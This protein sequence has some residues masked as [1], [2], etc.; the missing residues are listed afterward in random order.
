MSHRRTN[1]T[2][3]CAVHELAVMRAHMY[4]TRTAQQF[5][6]IICTIYYI[7]FSPQGCSTHSTPMRTPSDPCAR[8]PTRSLIRLWDITRQASAL[9]RYMRQGKSVFGQ[10]NSPC[11]QILPNVS[12]I[13]SVITKSRTSPATHTLRV[14]NY[15]PTY[16]LGIRNNPWFSLSQLQRRIDLVVADCGFANSSTPVQL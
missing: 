6:S 8:W 10:C 2:G 9:R 7:L 13:V 1:G 12:S 16:T 4:C 11:P 5:I 14:P 3:D 15:R